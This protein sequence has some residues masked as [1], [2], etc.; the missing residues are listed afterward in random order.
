MSSLLHQ[1]LTQASVAE[2][3]ERAQHARRSR[4]ARSERRPDPYP[5]VLVRMGGADDDAAALLR[6]SELEGLPVPRGS[7]LVAEVDGEVL[8]AHSL[9]GT[10]TVADP[11]R[12]TAHLV[13]LLELRSAHLRDGAKGLRSRF[14]RPRWLR[15]LV[16]TART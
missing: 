13:E 8:A 5:A 3:L 4:A 7:L 16:S 10:G 2:R 15:A 14:R 11:F 9:T 6:L 1:A 12:P